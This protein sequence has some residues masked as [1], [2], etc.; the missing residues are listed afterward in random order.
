M[1]RAGPGDAG[2]AVGGGRRRGTG[3]RRRD[4]RTG[5]DDRQRLDAGVGCRDRGR[6]W[7]RGAATSTSPG[8]C[9]PTRWWR[10]RR[11][12]SP[13]RRC[14]PWLRS[15]CSSCPSATMRPPP[16]SSPRP[17]RSSP[18][19]GFRDPEVVPLGPDAAEAL[20]ALGRSDE[21][22]PIVELLE[23]T[24]ARPGRWWARAVGA[25]CR[26]LMLAA[27]GRPRRRGGGVCPC[28]RR[29]SRRCRCCATTWRA[30]CWCS[31]SCNAVV[32][33]AVAARDVTAASRRAVRRGRARRAGRSPPGPNSTASACSPVRPIS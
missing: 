5:A 7:R 23:S 33:N 26:G 29:A 13:P 17:Q 16:A 30:R 1:A 25:R 32:A 19:S 8:P 28:R 9:C 31:A 22:A 10:W 2:R 24:G 6:S 3:L 20:I 15:G 4:G 27:V 21:A 14:T 18:R 12:G 11:L